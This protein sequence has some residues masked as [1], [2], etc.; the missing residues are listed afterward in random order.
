MRLQILERFTG[1]IRFFPSPPLN[2][3]QMIIIIVD[4]K[5]LMNMNWV[6]LTDGFKLKRSLLVYKFSV[7]TTVCK[8]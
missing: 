6:T 3:V 1:S 8:R 5:P 7:N 4:M 2:K